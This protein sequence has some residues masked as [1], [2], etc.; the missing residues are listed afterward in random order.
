MRLLRGRAPVLGGGQLLFA[1][2]RDGLPAQVVRASVHDLEGL[3]RCG[4]ADPEHALDDWLLVAVRLPGR[5]PVHAVG[6]W[7]HFGRLWVTSPL[8]HAC[9]EAG[10]VAGPTGPV[11]GLEGEHGP[12]LDRWLVEFVGENLQN[13]GVQANG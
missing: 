11:Y 12:G 9:L 3:P 4:V 8:T 13:W 1:G 6:R 2:S 7:T 10:C 5:T